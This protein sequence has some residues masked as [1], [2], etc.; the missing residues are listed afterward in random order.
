MNSSNNNRDLDS[1]NKL[2][3]TIFGGYFGAIYGLILIGPLAT[4]FCN[5]TYSTYIDVFF[6]CLGLACLLFLTYSV[7][8]KSLDWVDLNYR[9]RLI[10]FPFGRLFDSSVDNAICCAIEQSALIGSSAI[11]M[12]I[13]CALNCG[14]TIMWATGVFITLLLQ[15]KASDMMV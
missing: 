1:L 9:S 3:N 14:N 4:T 13:F 10:D 15:I 7:I 2:S 5:Y 8:R 6:K 12:S 11:V